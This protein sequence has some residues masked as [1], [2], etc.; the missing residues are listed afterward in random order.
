MRYRKFA[1]QNFRGIEK[2]QLE[3]PVTPAIM[4]L[5][6]L[7]ESGKTTILEAMNYFRYN[8]ESLEALDIKG[9]AVKD[10]HSLIPISKQSNF[11]EVIEIQFEVELSEDDVSALKGHL[12]ST[13]KVSEVEGVSGVFKITQSLKFED[14]KFKSTSNTWGLTFKVKKPKK[15]GLHSASGEVWQA[16]V[17]F[18]KG[19]L[20]PIMYFPTFSL[21][22]PDKIYLENPPSED[23]KH[24]F[25]AKVIQDILASVGSGA[26][27]DT[28]IAKRLLSGS[29]YDKVPLNSTLLDIGRAVTRAITRAWDEILNKKSGIQRVVLDSGVDF[30]E[31]AEIQRPYVQFKIEGADGY[32]SLHERSVGFRWFFSF[33]LLTQFRVFRQGQHKN[34]LFLFDEPASNLHPTAQMRLLESLPHLL[35]AGTVIYTTHSH[36]LVNVDWLGN[37]FV[38]KNEGASREGD[39]LDQAGETK[40]VAMPYARF[41]NQYPD[42]T[43][44]FK[45][46]LDVLDYVPSKLDSIEFAILLEGKSDFYAISLANKEIGLAVSL[47]P[48]MGAG[49]LDTLIRL[50]SGWGK[51]FAVLLDSDAEG[52]KQKKRYRDLFG[53]LVDGRLYTYGDIDEELKNATVESLLTKDDVERLRKIY[54]PGES[55]IGKKSILNALQQSCANSAS[56]SFSQEA[57]NRFR[58]ILEHLL[59]NA[60][61]K[62]HL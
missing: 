35:K 20:P 54:F 49:G 18:L 31:G 57:S 61:K 45:P 3:L 59:R 5:V 43:F 2:L 16:A 30:D 33:L 1:A 10:S 55:S 60:P 11:N 13:Q 22:I 48:G 62:T 27:V 47:M 8:P 26:T 9:Y 42:Q 52:E 46:I 21:E 19:R 50:Y 51:D 28:H 56:F 41:V 15:K 24:I 53:P 12:L 36:H 32:F 29:A 17:D 6:G 7:N 34:A 23:R 25:Y 40:I 38:V 58:C 44:F 4:T 39:L 37:A 14:S